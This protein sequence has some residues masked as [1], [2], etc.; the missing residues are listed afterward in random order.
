MAAGK[1]QIFIEQNADFIMRLRFKMP[2]GTGRDLTGHE[3]TGMLRTSATAK[4]APAA[5]FVFNMPDQTTE[6]GKGS[7][8]A[9][10]PA[11]ET[12]VMPMTPNKTAEKVTTD[13]AWD[14]RSVK[15][16]RTYRWLQGIAT[17]SPAVTRPDLT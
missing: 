1:N 3:F 6:D 11:S 12:V 9:T 10:I 7:L 17:V 4:G 14:L 16:G 8:I 15:D 13:F 5:N 2:D